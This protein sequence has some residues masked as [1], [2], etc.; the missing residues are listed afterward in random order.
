[1]AEVTGL[2]HAGENE[3][4]LRAANTLSN[5][6]NADRRP[7]GLAGPPRIVSHREFVFPLG[8]AGR[9]GGGA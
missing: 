3:L 8:E 4:E 6:L 2:V 5:L 7:S 1:M 9:N